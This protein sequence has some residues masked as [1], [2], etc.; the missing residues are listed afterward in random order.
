MELRRN[1]LFSL[2]F[3]ITI[4]TVAF[5]FIGRDTSRCASENFMI[6]SLFKEMTGITSQ[7]SYDVRDNKKYVLTSPRPRADRTGRHGRDVFMEENKT[8]RK[9]KKGDIISSS[10]QNDDNHISADKKIFMTGYDD[11]VKT[12]SGA[13][14]ESLHPHV[15]QD[16]ADQGE[17]SENFISEQSTGSS[18]TNNFKGSRAISPYDLIR[19]AIEK[20][21]TYP[22]LA[23]KRKIE[24]TV[25]TGFVIDNK[26]YPQDIKVKKSSGYEILDAAA[27]QI[28]KNAAPLPYVKGK[29]TVPISFK[30]TDY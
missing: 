12:S 16:R 9:I 23:R 4:I 8:A 17:G 27:V 24:G 11:E 19:V 29:I 6:V 14:H 21:K 18:A 13:G 25:I 30:L 5:L 15:Y 22:F 3:H 26:G 1:I 10:F 2:V 20:A 28:V 7:S